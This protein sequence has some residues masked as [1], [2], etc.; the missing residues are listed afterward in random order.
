MAITFLL[1][2]HSLA[3][4]NN[5]PETHKGPRPSPEATLYI[6]HQLVEKGGGRNFGLGSPTYPPVPGL[7]Q[8]QTLAPVSL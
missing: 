6:F 3:N 5:G 1:T 4:T 7:K 2:L 8:H